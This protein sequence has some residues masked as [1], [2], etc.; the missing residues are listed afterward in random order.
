MVSIRYEIEPFLHCVIE[1]QV[2]TNQF[3]LAE[4]MATSLTPE[5]VEVVRRSDEARAWQLGAL[6]SNDKTL[7]LR[8]HPSDLPDCIVLSS[9]FRHALSQTWTS[10]QRYD[11]AL[12]H[13]FISYLPTLR[14]RMLFGGESSTEAPLWHEGTVDKIDFGES[15]FPWE[16]LQVRWDYSAR[17][18]DN[19]SPW[20][21][22]RYSQG[23]PLQYASLEAIHPS[24]AEAIL[25]RIEA[26]VLLLHL[27]F[28]YLPGLTLFVGHTNPHRN[29]LPST[30]RFKHRQRVF[31]L[32]RI[33]Y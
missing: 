14:F 16:C 7:V 27:K 19:V 11:R 30:C 29:T 4:L 15:S 21:V 17:R 24:L 23:Q 6:A 31:D 20:E 32:H 28:F 3:Q 1:L 22:L 2:A 18:F 33:P 9:R 26:E 8:Y 13:S 10:G 25:G 5:Q 12:L